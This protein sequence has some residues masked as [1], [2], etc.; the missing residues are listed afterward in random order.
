MVGLDFEDPY[1]NG[2]QKLVQ[3]Q[4][5]IGS[6]NFVEFGTGHGTKTVRA[7][8]GMAPG[9]H[10]YAYDLSD[11]HLIELKELAEQRL[12]PAEAASKIYVA[13]GS[14][15]DNI[16]PI[17]R[18][19]FDNPGP[20]DAA[21]IFRVLHFLTEEDIVRSLRILYSYMPEGA[22]IIATVES[23]NL[24]F[25]PDE[26]R[27]ENLAQF[28]PN[29]PLYIP[30]VSK[31]YPGSVGARSLFTP[32]SLASLFKRAHFVVDKCTYIGREVGFPPP[33]GYPPGDE[34][35]RILSVGI[36]A[37]KRIRANASEREF[38]RHAKTFPHWY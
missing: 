2:W 14:L 37:H 28:G 24:A 26:L 13:Q 22:M 9:S 16:S 10:M 3:Y 4:S 1:V 33:I 6:F 15:P 21:A 35:N 11:Q 36:F 32:T 12:G 17:G 31:Y 38:R 30:D 25:I 23:M 29:H 20:I 5:A 7:A 18:L 34:R 19:K 8:E 27:K